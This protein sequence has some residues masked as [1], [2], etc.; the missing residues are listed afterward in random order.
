[1]LVFAPVS[2]CLTCAPRPAR[3]AR[4][5]RRRAPRR[6]R[7]RR[8][9][10]ASSARAHAR[11]GSRP[12]APSEPASG[13]SATTS[14]SPLYSRSGSIFAGTSS[15]VG[16]TS[17]AKSALRSA[18]A[19]SSSPERLGARQPAVLR[20]DHDAPA[21]RAVA[22][23]DRDHH[24]A[25]LAGGLLEVADGLG[26]VALRERDGVD[27]LGHGLLEAAPLGG[28]ALA[29]G[30]DLLELLLLEP[31]RLDLLLS[32]AICRA[33][34]LRTVRALLAARDRGRPRP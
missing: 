7:C 24:V 11:A 16:T 23:V 26:H 17:T 9:P 8:R 28:A 22:G 33:C 19:W 31:Q 27:G 14:L 12:R 13:S 4:A 29:L 32:S 25:D 5:P 30:L 18:I 34:A 21:R 3:R 6:R 10:S 20:L 1:M 15:S 2:C